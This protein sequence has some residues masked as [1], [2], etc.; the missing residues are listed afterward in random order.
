VVTTVAWRKRGRLDVFPL[1]LILGGAVGNLIDRVRLGEVVDFVQ[2]GIPPENAVAVA[3]LLRAIS[4]IMG[5]IGGLFYLLRDKMLM[6]P[7][8][9][10]A[11]AAAENMP[12][13]MK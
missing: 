10:E 1:G 9:P 6:H 5:L 11:E 3:L 2:I 4:I 7:P 13:N 8:S 12:D